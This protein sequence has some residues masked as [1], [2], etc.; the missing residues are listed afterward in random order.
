MC[1]LQCC[2][3]APKY[4]VFLFS[5][6][7]T[8]SSSG[9]EVEMVTFG[10]SAYYPPFHYLDNDHQ[11][12]GFDIDIFRVI[13][14][15]AGW[16]PDYR[17]GDW[18]RIQEELASGQIDMV[19]MFVSPERQARYLF[20]DPFNMEYHQLFG[21][22][23]MVSHR[24]FDTLVGY[25]VAMEDGAYAM[26]ELKKLDLDI[27][28]IAA[29][30]EADALRMTASGHADLA[31]L[32]AG[33][34]RHTIDDENLVN[35]V[36]LSP[37]LLPV[38]YA[39]AIS[40]QRPELLPTVNEA[41][42][43]LQRQGVI[44]QFRKQWLEVRAPLTLQQALRESIAVVLP[45]AVL[46]ALAL[47]AFLAYR[48]RWQSIMLVMHQQ[49]RQLR[50]ARKKFK[51]LTDTDPLTG[52]PDRDCFRNFLS[53]TL[54]AATFQKYSVAV[55][56]LAL[57]DLEY[58]QHTAGFNA[59]D[60]LVRQIA[61][62]IKSHYQGPT[63][64]IGTGRFAFIFDE[65]EDRE[66]AISQINTLMALTSRS[67]D[68]A[69]V[70]V[71]VQVTAGLA[72]FPNHSGDESELLRKAD[73]AVIHAQDKGLPLLIYDAS[74]EPSPRSL[75]LMSDLKA[76]LLAGGLSW[77]YQPQ[78]CVRSKR[79]L[80]AEMLIRWQHPDHGWVPPDQFIVQ[81][82]EAG[83]IKDVTRE[84]FKQA[85]AILGEWRQSG[86]EN[87]LSINVSAN[88][89]A[90]RRVVEEM[91]ERLGDFAKF[92]TL[93]ITETA[94]MQDRQ[95]IIANVEVLKR[96]GVKIA[97]DDYGTGYS[98]LEYLK[99]FNFDEIKIDRT[100]IQDIAQS[101]R[102]LT[103]ATASITL[104][105]SLGAVVVAEGVEDE[106]TIEIL[107]ERGCDI[108]QG[109]GISRPLDFDAFMQFTQVSRF[110]SVRH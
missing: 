19:P 13:A 37:P 28:F 20:S 60:A 75:T 31:F 22:V 95:S 45:L 77:V 15:E 39:F 8:I 91:T 84:V 21:L 26:Q 92:L 103:L 98:S 78:F 63:G 90:D 11:A 109:Y 42:L 5:V 76:T 86:Q 64:Y 14:R 33:I 32:P 106:R 49:R 50:S 96:A 65:L 85:I 83:L 56:V 102:N 36:A 16:E 4:A 29:T 93:E 61:K 104:G 53:Q 41:I 52:L 110:N 101:E 99:E 59:A 10:G 17:F 108:L 35:L 25:R 44:D 62:L 100:F 68:V 48:N 82:E 24:S 87:R 88:D 97:L 71:H 70:P 80:G 23:D 94:I 58:I 51:Q 69:G 30:S 107:V 2:K 9:A 72:L 67:L 3:Q 43:S 74:M 81:A 79:I 1:S 57:R 55:G 34:A 6:W 73:L 12:G 47:V 27:E 18:P 7:I 40:P 38:S 46:A 66:K 89:L 105:H 54:A